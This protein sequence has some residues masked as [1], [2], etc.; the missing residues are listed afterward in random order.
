M[1]RRV[2]R[3]DLAVIRGQRCTLRAVRATDLGALYELINDVSL[4]GE[5]LALPLR[6]EPSFR[7]EFDETGFLDARRGR[8]LV[9][10][11]ADHV[12]GTVVYFAVNSMDGFEIGYHL[13]DP[14]ARNKGLMTEAVRLAVGYLF[15]RHKINRLQIA[16]AVDN[17]A[18]KRLALKCGF[19]LEGTLRGN[20]FQHGRNCDSLL[21]SLLR[22]EAVP[23]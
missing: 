6:S 17:E 8:F 2:D 21:Y 9:T 15:S 7:K 18:S 20:V 16:T 11:A 13:F 22:S 3:Q 5:H 4:Q 23:G 1:P 14:Q 19:R 10:D 12:L